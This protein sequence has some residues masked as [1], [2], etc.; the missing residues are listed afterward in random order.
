MITCI[1]GKTSF[2]LP[3]THAPKFKISSDILRETLKGDA[4]ILLYH[5]FPYFRTRRV[6]VGFAT[7]LTLRFWIGFLRVLSKFT[8]W[9]GLAPL[10]T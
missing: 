9:S 5:R 1:F 8:V 3:D 2:L 7:S 10:R 4:M 6:V